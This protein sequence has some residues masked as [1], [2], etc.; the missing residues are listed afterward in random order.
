M[1]FLSRN[2]ARSC[3]HSASLM[4]KHQSNTRAPAAQRQRWSLYDVPKEAPL[5]F[6]PFWNEERKERLLCHDQTGSAGETSLSVRTDSRDIR[7]KYTKRGRTTSV[8]ALQQPGR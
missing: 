1:F 7:Q 4:V 3:P 5:E 6:E 8:L 2:L